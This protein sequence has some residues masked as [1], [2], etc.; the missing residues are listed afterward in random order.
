MTDKKKLNGL[1]GGFI[2]GGL[3][4]GV[5]ALLFAPK[6]GKRLRE[7]IRGRANELIDEG[8]KKA[9]DTWSAAREKAES[10]FESANDFLNT[11]VE[12]VARKAEKIKD[13]LKPEQN[14][15]YD[16]VKPG[17]Q[18]KNIKSQSGNGKETDSLGNT[19]VSQSDIMSS[20]TQS[21]DEKSALE[22][23]AENTL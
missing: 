17:R 21:Y 12:K 7:D 18:N 8:R 19:I 9:N 15:L 13:A 1:I 3:A 2:V 14:R 11:G 6:S 16:D 23:D 20:Q 22:K 5:V 4:G 10:T